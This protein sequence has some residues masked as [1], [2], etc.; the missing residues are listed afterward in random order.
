MN[1][2]MFKELCMLR[3][4]RTI[5]LS[6]KYSKHPLIRTYLLKCGK[7]GPFILEYLLAI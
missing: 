2:I 5:Q 7:V 6:I 4:V 1:Y 3:L